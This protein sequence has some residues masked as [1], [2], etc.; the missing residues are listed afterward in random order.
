MC[1]IL[2][3]IHITKLVWTWMHLRYFFLFFKFQTIRTNDIGNEGGCAICQSLGANNKIKKLD[4]SGNQLRNQLCLQISHML[5]VFVSF[6]GHLSNRTS[7]LNLS[8][9]FKEIC[10]FI[11]DKLHI[12]RIISQSKLNRRPRRNGAGWYA[13]CVISMACVET[14]V[15]N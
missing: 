5:E 1:K 7:L 13:R 9:Y 2:L 15:V 10:D 12:E 14:I 11:A 3:V 4:L 6:L 8:Q